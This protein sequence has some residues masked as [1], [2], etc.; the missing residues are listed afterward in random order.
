MAIDGR[1]VIMSGY[2]PAPTECGVLFVARSSIPNWFCTTALID[3]IAQTDASVSEIAMALGYSEQTLTN[4]KKGT[5]QPSV[6]DVRELFTQFG[7]ADEEQ[8]LGVQGV[9]RA[10]KFDLKELELDA[11]FN[12]LLIEKCE[13]H[14]NRIFVWEP[15]RIPGPFQCAPYH[16]DILQVL[17]GTPDDRAILGRNR[18]ER[19]GKT[20]RGRT[21]PFL[22]RYIIGETA[23]LWLREL[24]PSERREQLDLLREW[25]SLPIFEIRIMA[26][27][28]TL[29]EH[30]FHFDPAG[31]ATAGPEFVLI[32]SRDRTR[33]VEDPTLVKLYTDQIEPNWQRATSLEDHFAANPD[34][35]A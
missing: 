9:V 35:F 23:L 21:P 10:K 31:S 25:N 1:H 4:W 26:R 29:D 6:G 33:C 17:E 19:R 8:I 32:R 7:N 2:R 12:G 18:K 28:N 30:F 11:R 27:P 20:L 34:L 13:R 22:N 24:A 5:G 3:C 15:D 14:Y 16:F